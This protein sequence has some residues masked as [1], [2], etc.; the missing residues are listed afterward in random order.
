MI[1]IDRVLKKVRLDDV[2]I[3][4]HLDRIT[5]VPKIQLDQC[6]DVNPVDRPIRQDDDQL[7]LLLI[8]VNLLEDL[9]DGKHHIE[10]RIVTEEELQRRSAGIPGHIG[11]EILI[12]QTLVDRVDSIE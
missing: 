4:R 9:Y 1:A 3:R 6:R 11:D 10:F 5:G 12:G 2:L 8:I 7:F